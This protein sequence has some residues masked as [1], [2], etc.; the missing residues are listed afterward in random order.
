MSITLSNRPARLGRNINT[1]TE[2]HGEET[3]PA[4]D[5]PIENFMLDGNEL[6]ALLQDP[7]AHNTLF[8]TAPG[9]LVEPRLKSLK[10]FQLSHAF[11][12]CTPSLSIGF[13]NERI[14]LTGAELANV[15][16]DPCVGGLTELSGLF[17][18]PQPDLELLAKLMRRLAQPIELSLYIGD[19]K[20]APN[21]KQQALPLNDS[22]QAQPA[23]EPDVPDGW[24]VVESWPTET[25]GAVG[26]VCWTA[27]AAHD[28]IGELISEGE[29]DAREYVVRGIR[30][31]REPQDPGQAVAPC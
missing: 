19:P 24:M 26:V 8:R 30:I 16:L 6:N 29:T 9:G 31:I 11:E 18:W 2:N 15:K 7:Q 20:K 21:D 22:T 12:K 1:R 23:P 4:A 13:D 25:E 17:K 27:L 3:K 10:T 14:E 5:V 28:H